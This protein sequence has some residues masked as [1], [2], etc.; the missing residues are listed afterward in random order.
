MS[1]DFM[2]SPEMGRLLKA[3]RD[4]LAVRVE[5]LDASVAMYEAMAKA[6]ETELFGNDFGRSR[7]E[8][9]ERA[10][11]LAVVRE[12]L[13]QARAGKAEAGVA[14][15]G[16]SVKDS[17]DRLDDYAQIKDAIASSMIGGPG[18]RLAF[19]ALDR[20]AAWSGGVSTASSATPDSSCCAAARRETDTLREALQVVWDRN[21]RAIERP[22]KPSTWQVVKSALAAVSAEDLRETT[23]S[24]AS[25]GKE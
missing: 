14:A 13:E 1:D 6:I 21:F 16:G 15:S 24:E 8:L 23:L 11:E 25:Q 2:F 20:L 5:E 17:K 4:A 18:K 19:K 22:D 3:E 12:E 10:A 9:V 7:D